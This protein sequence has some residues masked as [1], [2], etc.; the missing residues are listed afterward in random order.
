[1]IVLVAEY[2]SAR[3][4]HRH[5]HHFRRAAPKERRCRAW[6]QPVAAGVAPRCTT[7]WW[8]SAPQKKRGVVETHSR[9]RGVVAVPK[10]AGGGGVSTYATGGTLSQRCS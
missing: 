7:T 3:P 10:A 4:W 9:S 1:M 5:A 2:R 6:W 8:D